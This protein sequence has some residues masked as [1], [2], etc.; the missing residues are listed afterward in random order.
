MDIDGLGTAF[1][2]MKS[3]KLLYTRELRVARTLEERHEE[4]NKT[5]NVRKKPTIG[6]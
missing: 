1:H 5:Q 2:H 3:Y 4:E 6:R